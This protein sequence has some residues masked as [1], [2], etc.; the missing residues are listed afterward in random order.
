MPKSIV[1]HSNSISQIPAALRYR[2]QPREK[3]LTVE[4]SEFMELEV[5][6]EI[7]FLTVQ[8]PGRPKDQ[9][10]DERLLRIQKQNGCR[11]R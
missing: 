5:R 1:L 10:V 2:S 4:Y 11:G 7:D 6:S 9:G 3:A 8:C